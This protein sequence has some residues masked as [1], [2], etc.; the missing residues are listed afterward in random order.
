MNTLRKSVRLAMEILVWTGAIAG[1]LFLGSAS[2]GVIN[3]FLP[4]VMP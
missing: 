3:L 2:S 1:V 4:L